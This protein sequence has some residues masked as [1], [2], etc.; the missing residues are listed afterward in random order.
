MERAAL[1]CDGLLI[2]RSHVER[3][4]ASNPIKR[5]QTLTSPSPSDTEDRSLREIERNELRTQ[6]ETHTGSRAE[7][8]KKLG[9]SE[10]SLYRK[11][12]ALD[13]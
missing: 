8:S 7:L 12:R 3:S 6:L 5:I 1:L 4:V 9:M 13:K 11:L 2:E 10:R